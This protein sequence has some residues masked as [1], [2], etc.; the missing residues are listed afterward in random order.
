[1]RSGG[2]SLLKNLAKVTDPGNACNFFNDAA[3]SD[4]ENKQP[5]TASD[6]VMGMF[7]NDNPCKEN[8]GARARQ[9]PIH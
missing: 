2:I 8:V 5:Y 6:F 9:M 7:I 4:V 3:D 1:M